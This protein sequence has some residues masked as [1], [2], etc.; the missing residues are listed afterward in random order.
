[1]FGKHPIFTK[2]VTDRVILQMAKATSQNKKNGGTTENVVRIHI[3]VIIIGYCLVAIALHDIQHPCS[4]YQILQI[5]RSHLSTKLHYEN[6]SRKLISRSSRNLIVHFFKDY[7]I[8]SSFVQILTGH[9]L[10]NVSST[11]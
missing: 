2:Q 10:I 5:Q 8:K 11:N 6:C 7:L 1:M 9:Y 4:N 3:S